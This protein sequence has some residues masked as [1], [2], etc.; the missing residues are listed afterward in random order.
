MAVEPREEIISVGGTKVHT[1]IGG[2]GAPLLSLHGAGGPPGWRRWHAA[3]AERFTVYVPAHPGYGL[4]DAAEWMESVPD[5][6]AGWA[7]AVLKRRKRDGLFPG[8]GRAR[9][10]L[11]FIGRL[12]PSRIVCEQRGRAAL[13]AAGTAC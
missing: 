2:R 5:A 10:H 13:P 12:A 3:L 8:S 1:L 11:V 6:L 4:S 7:Q 9:A